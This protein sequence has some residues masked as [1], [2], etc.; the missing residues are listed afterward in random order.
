MA[1]EAH[2]A[3]AANFP[4]RAD[5]YGAYFGEFLTL[6]ADES[7]AM[8]AS[9][10][11]QRGEFSDRFRAAL[12]EV[13]AVACPAGGRPF[14]YARELQYGGMADLEQLVRQLHLRF[15]FPADLAGTPSLSLPCG[16]SAN[17]LPYTIQLLGS[18]LSEP[19]LCRI[20]HAYE[21]ATGWHQRHPDV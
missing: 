12:S 2:A 3:H 9:A 20:G 4:S 5:E 16:F 1:F 7:D 15:T 21:E 10:N 8:Y 11:Q 6:G 14:V 13:D 19:M 18:R 17:G